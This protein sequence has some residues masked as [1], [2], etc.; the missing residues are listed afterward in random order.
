MFLAFILS[1]S[2]SLVALHFGVPCTFLQLQHLV[3][4]PGNK[5]VIMIT[6]WFFLSKLNFMQLNFM[7]YFN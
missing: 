1:G 3:T 7:Q 5:E 6:T 4:L 2:F